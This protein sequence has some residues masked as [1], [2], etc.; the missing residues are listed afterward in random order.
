MSDSMQ[1]VITWL[2]VMAYCV[3]L[4]FITEGSPLVGTILAAIITP[5]VFWLMAV[6]GKAAQ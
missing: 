3:P 2:I 4:A 1:G 5:V 6:K